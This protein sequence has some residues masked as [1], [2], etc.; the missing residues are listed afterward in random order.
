[1]ELISSFLL[2]LC[3]GLV[4]GQQNN[5]EQHGVMVNDCIKSEVKRHLELMKEDVIK[6]EVDKQ[7]EEKLN[8]RVKEE[9]KKELENVR[10]GKYYANHR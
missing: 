6:A 8:K 1:M 5:C 4:N 9:L 3:L 10:E 2:L 7:V